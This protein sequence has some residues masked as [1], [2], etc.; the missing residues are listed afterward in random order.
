[1][2]GPSLSVACIQGD[3]KTPQPPAKGP[4]TFTVVK[5]CKTSCH[6][7]EQSVV[8]RRRKR[9]EFQPKLPWSTQKVKLLKQARGTSNLNNSSSSSALC[10]WTLHFARGHV[11]EWTVQALPKNW[12]RHKVTLWVN[13]GPAGHA[14]SQVPTESSDRNPILYLGEPVKLTVVD[15]GTLGE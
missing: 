2:G 10:T 15:Q 11:L 6:W 5:P 7:Q 9:P 8:A 13:H 14:N 3:L 12:L 4:S 1:M